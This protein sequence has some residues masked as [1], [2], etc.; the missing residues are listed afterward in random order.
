MNLLY[1]F[2]GLLQYIQLSQYFLAGEEAGGATC[3]GKG[4]GSRL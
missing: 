2:D 1:M 3:S 4:R